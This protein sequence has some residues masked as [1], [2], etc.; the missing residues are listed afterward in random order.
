MGEAQAA[1]TSRSSSEL[2]ALEPSLRAWAIRATGDPEASRDLVQETLAAGLEAAARF[3]GRSTLRTWLIG[4]L[5]HKVADHFRRLYKAPFEPNDPE[6][7][8]L[9]ATPS[10]SEVERVV[11]ARRDLARVDQALGQLPPGERL[12]L[13]LVGVEGFDHEEACR[14]M[15]VTATHLRVLLHRGRHHLRRLLEREL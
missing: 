11:M 9:L 15:A 5:S 14:E 6:S 2:A 3:D 13:L 1:P 7:P 10:G 12:A 8:D 4:V